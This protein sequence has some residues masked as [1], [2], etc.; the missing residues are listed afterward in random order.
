VPASAADLPAIFTQLGHSNSDRLGR[1]G[2]RR[3]TWNSASGLV[4]KGQELPNLTTPGI[5]SMVSS[6]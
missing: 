6:R 4:A 2:S 3:Q 1:P 5:G